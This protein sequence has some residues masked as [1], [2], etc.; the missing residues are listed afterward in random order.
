MKNVRNA[1]DLST[2]HLSMVDRGSLTRLVGKTSRTQACCTVPFR[3][4]DTYYGYVMFLTDDVEQERGHCEDAGLPFTDGFWKIRKVAEENDCMLIN[5]DC[6][7]EIID[8][9]ETYL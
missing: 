7:A 6:D 3:V 4:Y 9:L 5:F 2:A 8:G 1:L